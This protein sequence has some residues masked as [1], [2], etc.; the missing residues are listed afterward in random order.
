M[1]NHIRC[2]L[3]LAYFVFL[4]FARKNSFAILILDRIVCRLFLRNMAF[5]KA[6]FLAYLGE[7]L[8]GSDLVVDQL[9]DSNFLG[10]YITVDWDFD[11]FIIVLEN[12]R[13]FKRTIEYFVH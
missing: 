7:G 11:M 3:T 12:S 10:C 2:L 9:L 8:V 6:V 1:K 5:G 4:V 13:S